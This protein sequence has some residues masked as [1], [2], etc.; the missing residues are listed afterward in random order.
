MWRTS[1]P[2]DFFRWPGTNLGIFQ[3]WPDYS[4]VTEDNPARPGEIL[5]TYLTG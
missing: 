4:L 2:G 3:H 5:I 1:I